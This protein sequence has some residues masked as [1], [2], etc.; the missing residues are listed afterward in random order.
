[1]SGFARRIAMRSAVLA[2]VMLAAV[3]GPLHAEVLKVGDRLVELDTAVDGAGKPFKLK[4]LRGKW[5]LV[6]IGAEW[7]EACVK[8][9]PT[10]DKLAPDWKDK[11]AFVAINVNDNVDDGK[12]FNKKLKLANLTLVYMPQDKSGVVDRY[13]SEH[14]PSTFIADPKGI[15]QFVRDGFEKEDTS[16]ELSK[17][18]ATLGKLVK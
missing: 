14:M 3:A 16:G 4:A 9:L 1:M 15:V 7:C 13:G 10:W 6:T 2:M 12:R 5:V 17:M 18:K 11:V 8:E